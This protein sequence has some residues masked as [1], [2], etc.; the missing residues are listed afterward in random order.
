MLLP[1]ETYLSFRVHVIAWTLLG[2]FLMILF[3]YYSRKTKHKYE[4]LREK[5]VFRTKKIEV[6]SDDGRVTEKSVSVKIKVKLLKDRLKFVVY[7]YGWDLDRFRKEKRFFENIYNRQLDDPIQMPSRF[8]QNVVEFHYEQFKSYD[9][10]RVKQSS[11]QQIFSGINSKS[12][13]VFVNAQNETSLIVA[14]RSGS[15][16]S[17]TLNVIA[18]NFLDNNS[19]YRPI[20]V[21]TKSRDFEGLVEHWHRLDDLESYKRLDQ[22]LDR[23]IVYCNKFN[24]EGESS[25]MKWVIILD[26]ALD[27]L[28]KEKDYDKEIQKVKEA[29]QAKIIK[30][31]RKLRAQG[32]IV[33]IGL[34][35]I[36]TQAIVVPSSLIHNR[37]IGRVS[38]IQQ[39]QSL[40]LGLDAIDEDLK[41][42]RWISSVGNGQKVQFPLALKEAGKTRYTGIV[43]FD[44]K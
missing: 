44:G 2:A 32:I 17:L 5:G 27:Y 14:G 34:Q 36:S 18:R 15:G 22:E 30:I 4:E 16:K 42:G 31:I 7:N 29:I 10:Y 28:G 24:K 25:P 35:D 37:L 8:G 11:Q 3:A 39:A 33:L 38:T 19:E 26:E 21:D 1:I 43:S 23:I 41:N 20:V 40:G 12:K 9:T 6:K 13:E